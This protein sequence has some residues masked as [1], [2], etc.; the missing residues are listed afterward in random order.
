MIVT[1]GPKGRNKSWQA[2]FPKTTPCTGCG[3]D[4]KFAAHEGL[5]EADK[6]KS[7]ERVTDLYLTRGR[8]NELWVH[9]FCAVAV[10]FCPGCLDATAVMNQ[11]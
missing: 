4:A 6:G 3:K 7:I 9:D 1:I 2:D 10:Y 8:K 5:D 11:A